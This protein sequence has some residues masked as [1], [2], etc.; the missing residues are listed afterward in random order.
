VQR[1][2]QQQPGGG[3]EDKGYAGKVRTDID[4]STYMPA[5]WRADDY[6][7]GDFQVGGESGGGG[8]PR[9]HLTMA[10]QIPAAAAAI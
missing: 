8:R 7:D 4:H 10:G 1:Q 6:L 5:A 2:D 3:T 9:M